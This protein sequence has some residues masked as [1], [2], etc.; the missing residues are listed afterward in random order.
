M[1]VDYEPVN[2]VIIDIATCLNKDKLIH[3]ILHNQIKS[4]IEAKE[5]LIFINEMVEFS[6]ALLKGENS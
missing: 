4:E 3:S 6:V 1:N 2:T 5:I